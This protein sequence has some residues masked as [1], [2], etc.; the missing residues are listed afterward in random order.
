MLSYFFE[1]DELCKLDMLL[2]LLVISTINLNN[3]YGNQHM[4]VHRIVFYS[5]AKLLV[6]KCQYALVHDFFVY[7]LI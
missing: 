2:V 1:S 7:N 6:Y 3:N 4:K 5:S